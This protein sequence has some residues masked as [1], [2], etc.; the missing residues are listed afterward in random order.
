[1]QNYKFEEEVKKTGLTGRSPLRKRRSALDCSCHLRRRRTE[2]P[3][4]EADHSAYSAEVK[5]DWTYISTPPYAF[6]AC[7]GMLL[8]LNL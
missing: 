8:N 5:N 1:M 7:R 6:I 3:G 2:R 4:R